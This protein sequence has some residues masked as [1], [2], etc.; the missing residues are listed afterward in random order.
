MKFLIGYNEDLGFLV[1]ELNYSGYFSFCCECLLPCRKSGVDY[2][3]IADICWDSL[4]SEDKL[5]L[6]EMNNCSPIEMR[7]RL[8]D[9]EEA[10]LC[11]DYDIDEETMPKINDDIFFELVSGGQ[12]DLREDHP[13]LFIPKTLF[14]RIMTDWD[15][16]HLK[17]TS[18]AKEE[19]DVLTDAISICG[20][21]NKETWYDF[22][23]E[24]IK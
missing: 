7:K 15:N 21:D 19:Y 13:D 10:L 22:V 5:Y 11:Y 18:K 8:R 3:E 12:H 24:K 1:G 23:L 6:C 14:D 16:Y 20:F 9:D 17:D 2:D 4:L